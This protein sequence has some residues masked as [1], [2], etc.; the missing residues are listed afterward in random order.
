MPIGDILARPHPA[1]ALPGLSNQTIADLA[2]QADQQRRA[3]ERR[4][5]LTVAAI[6]QCEVNLLTSALS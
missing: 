3:A 6:L 4:G 5:D 1:H 2:L